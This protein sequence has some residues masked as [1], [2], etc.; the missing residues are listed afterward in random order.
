M[1]PQMFEC[2]KKSLKGLLAICKAVS[3]LASLKH[4]AQLAFAFNKMKQEGQL[5]LKW[6]EGVYVAINRGKNICVPQS[7]T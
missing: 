1:M 3:C 6:V 5:L 4:T 2:K 7:S